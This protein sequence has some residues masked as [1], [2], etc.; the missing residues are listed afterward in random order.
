E[1]GWRP[2]RERDPLRF[3]SLIHAGLEAWW[4]AE[5]LDR[6]DAALEAIK[7]GVADEFERARAE[8]TIVAYHLRWDG[9]MADYEVLSVEPRFDAPLLNPATMMPSR[10]FRLAGRIDAILRRRADGRVLVREF[11]TTS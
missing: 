10:T 8:E 4:K 9:D 11:K 6:L 1:E 5:P 3:G 7:G 2:S